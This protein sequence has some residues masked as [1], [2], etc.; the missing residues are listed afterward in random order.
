MDYERECIKKIM[1]RNKVNCVLEII[2]N[3]V[4]MF[5]LIMLVDLL[6]AVL[7]GSIK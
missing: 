3:G 1:L 4:G 6:E 7:R 2:G 5:F